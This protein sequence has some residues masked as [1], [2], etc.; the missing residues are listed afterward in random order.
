MILNCRNGTPEQGFIDAVV[1]R[2]KNEKTIH[3]LLVLQR[4][5]RT[6]ETDEIVSLAR[7]VKVQLQKNGLKLHL[8]I[9][10]NHIEIHYADDDASSR[11]I[12]T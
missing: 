1:H 5:S 3:K 8:T 9:L 10:L 12:A 2:K 11:W 6:H 4:K 7:D